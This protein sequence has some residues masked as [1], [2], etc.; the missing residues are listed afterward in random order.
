MTGE[1]SLRAIDSLSPK[2]KPG[3]VQVIQMH[4]VFLCRCSCSADLANNKNKVAQ[5]FAR[6]EHTLRDTDRKR[7]LQTLPAIVVFTDLPD[8]GRYQE[9]EI[10]QED[11]NA[12]N[13]TYT[14][15]CGYRPGNDC[16]R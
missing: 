9:F 12:Q 5:I 4:S 13:N 8:S 11:N 15:L 3:F 10:F 7:E 14:Y 1:S 16:Q 6:W 2:T